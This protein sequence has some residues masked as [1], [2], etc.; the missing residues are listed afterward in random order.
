MD[1]E[2]REFLSWAEAEAG[3]RPNTLAAYR[4]DLADFAT[5]LERRRTTIARVRAKDVLAYLRQLRRSGRAEATLGRRFACLRS[6]FRFL[7]AEGRLRADP[8][9]TLDAPRKWRTLPRVPARDEVEALLGVI[10]HTARGRRDRALFEL[11]YATGARIGEV[12]GA[13]R[14]DYHGD[15]EILRL[16]GKGGKQRVV[17]VGR[18]ARTALAEYHKAEPAGPHAP[19]VGSLRGRP[20]TR[21]RVLRMLREYA[22]AA[23]LRAAPSPHGLRHAYATHMLEGNA[24]IRAVQE[25]L[26]HASVAT[27]QLYTHVEQERLRSIHAKYHPRA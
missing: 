6:F 21:D 2:T 14:R 11:L 20:L 7:M 9:G 25:L 17:P 1:G 23:G 26:G 3:W 15:L 24:D 12:L 19:L 22:A 27:T 5:F 16:H 8:T 4:R 10:P 18:A 13:A